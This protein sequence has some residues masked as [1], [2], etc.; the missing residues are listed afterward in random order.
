MGEKITLSAVEKELIFATIIYR[1][2]ECGDKIPM[3][4]QDTPWEFIEDVLEEMHEAD[5]LTISDDSQEWRLAAPKGKKLLG[6]LIAMGDA[7]LQF[8]VF[9]SFNFDMEIPDEVRDDDTGALNPEVWDSRFDPGCIEEGN[10]TEDLRLAM[11]EWASEKLRRA[12]KPVELDTTRIIYLQKLANGGL[13]DDARGFWH[14]VT[15][16][17]MFDEIQEIKDTA[18]KWQDLGEDEEDS[19]ELAGILY[20]AGMINLRKEEGMSC[21]E[22][23]TPLAM[24]EEDG[25]VDE[26]PNPECDAA[27]GD[28]DDD[29]SLADT[30]YECPKCKRGITIGQS[31][32]YGCG[33]A[34][35]FSLPSGTVGTVT[36]TET[37]SSSY[38][39]Y[40]GYGYNP[41]GYGSY[42]WYDPYDPVVDAMCFG[43]V[44]GAFL[45]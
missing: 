36:E 15:F 21:P 2:H 10:R 34:I 41:Y 18:Y 30:E 5:Y 37:T 7:S 29:D 32:C 23:E 8:E 24:F 6:K 35:D 1:L 16:R 43:V 3:L 17:Q 44:C 13:A 20:T 14:L 38:G 28:P 26:C 31:N 25:P 40:D 11:L 45:F 4:V 19:F 22:C 42:G 27:F 39:G 12:D 9:K 33:A